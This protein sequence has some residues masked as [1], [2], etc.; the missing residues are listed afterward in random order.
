MQAES[1]YHVSSLV[2]QFKPELQESIAQAL[3]VLDHVE[4]HG[5]DPVGKAVVVVDGD[6]ERSLADSIEE[7]RNV[8]GVITASVVFHRIG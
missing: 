3:N 4:L 7:I 1:E 8:P 5:I 6:D 2:V